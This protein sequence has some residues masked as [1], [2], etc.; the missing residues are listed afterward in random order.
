VIILEKKNFADVLEALSGEKKVF[1]AGCADCAT[2]CKVGGEEEVAEMQKKLQDAGFEVTG[3]CILDTACLSG[4]VRQKGRE[5]EDAIKNSDSI[6]VLACGTGA[7]TIGD[8]LGL[9]VH[10]GLESLFTGEVVRLGKYQEKCRACGECVLE[11]T[12][13][14]CPVTRCSKGL[15]N[16]PCGGYSKDGKCEVDPDKD[17]AWLL[18]YERL[19]ERGRLDKMKQFREPKDYSKML[20]PRR[21]VWKKPGAKVGGGSK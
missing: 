16:G 20:S 21:L 6:L 17:C 1:I 12:E 2:T 7:Q 8:S 4:E 9:R 18:I 19:K 15:L 14:I 5:Y 11:D 3:T 13:G 10:P